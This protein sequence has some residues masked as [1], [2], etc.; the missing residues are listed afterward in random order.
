MHSDERSIT[1]GGGN[2][3]GS[4]SI[5]IN[6]YFKDGYTGESDTYNNPQMTKNKDFKVLKFEVWGFNEF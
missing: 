1:L 2:D 5:F 3:K 4:S 6:N